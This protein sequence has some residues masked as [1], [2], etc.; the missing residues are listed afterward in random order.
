MSNFMHMCDTKAYEGLI[1]LVVS[2][3]LVGGAEEKHDSP[4]WRSNL[5]SFNSETQFKFVCQGDGPLGHTQT[6]RHAYLL[7]PYLLLPT[8][9]V[10][11]LCTKEKDN[12]L[13]KNVT[14]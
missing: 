7:Q 10:Y 9:H 4:F 11:P 13:I 2:R 8:K 6:R 14:T 12:E 5:G 1:Y 3:S